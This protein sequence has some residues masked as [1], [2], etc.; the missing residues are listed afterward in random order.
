MNDMTSVEH[1]C[2]FNDNDDYD[3]SMIKVYACVCALRE[4]EQIPFDKRFR[5]TNCRT[6]YLFDKKMKCM[7]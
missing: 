7:R 3:Y 5:S 2:T 1:S 4:N 6:F